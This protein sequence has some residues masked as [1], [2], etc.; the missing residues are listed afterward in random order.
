MEGVFDSSC[1]PFCR[2]EMKHGFLIGVH[3]LKEVEEMFQK[4]TVVASEQARGSPGIHVER[5]AFQAQVSFCRAVNGNVIFSFRSI[6]SS[7]R[8]FA[9]KKS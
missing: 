5:C 7:S 6:V 2:L 4:V 1:Y 9:I 8:Q 3:D